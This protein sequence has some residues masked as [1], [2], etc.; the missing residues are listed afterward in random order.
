MNP[1]SENSFDGRYFGLLPVTA[2]V[3]RADPLWTREED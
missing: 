3:G 2:V 1:Q